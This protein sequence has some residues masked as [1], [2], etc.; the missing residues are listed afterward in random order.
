MAA[1]PGSVRLV[2]TEI[3]R[4]FHELRHRD[5][6][7]AASIAVA[8]SEAVGNVVRHAYPGEGSGRVEVEAQLEES[9]HR[10][11]RERR[12]RR[13]DGPRKPSAQRHG[14]AGDRPAGRR[15]HGRLRQ[16]RALACQCASSSARKAVAGGSSR[17]FT[18]ARWPPYPNSR[19]V[20]ASK[21]G[22]SVGSIRDAGTTRAAFRPGCRGAA[23]GHGGRLLPRLRERA[24]RRHGRRP[25]ALREGGRGSQGRCHKHR[26]GAQGR[27]SDRERGRRYRSGPVQG[28][29]ARRDRALAVPRP[30]VGPQGRRRGPRGVREGAWAADHAPRLRGW[31]REVAAVVKA[32]PTCRL[33]SPI[34]ARLGDAS[35]WASTRSRIR[36]GLPRRAPRSRRPSHSSRR[37]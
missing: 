11:Q 7:L 25:G 15:R 24:G 35:S 37:R 2:R 10:G 8:V 1:E 5:D 36:L 23:L 17:R 4:W 6:G 26:V 29:R 20:P 27:R 22:G 9:M 14:T 16:R 34:R 32:T 21:R 19:P 33:R 12:G 13:D 28:F 31:W 18:S 3:M 30:F